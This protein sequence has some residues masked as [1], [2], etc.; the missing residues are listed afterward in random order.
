MAKFDEPN[1]LAELIEEDVTLEELS[2]ETVPVEDRLAS[3]NKTKASVKTETS[4][5]VIKQT[6]ESDLGNK[7]DK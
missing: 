5:E 7:G 6:F 4:G 1:D 3:E 2:E